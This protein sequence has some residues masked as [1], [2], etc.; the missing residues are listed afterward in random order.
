[1]ENSNKIKLFLVDDHSLFL[2]GLKSLLSK[3][4]QYSIVGEAGNGLEFLAAFESARPDVVL[5]D[6][7]MPEMDGIEAS[8]KALEINPDLKIITLSMYGDQEYYT[9]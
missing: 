8:R 5:M 6:I 1:M 4:P 3:N 7:S 9:K 2:N